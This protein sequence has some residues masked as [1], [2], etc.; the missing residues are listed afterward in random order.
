MSN[1]HAR[2]AIAGVAVAGMI[3]GTMAVGDA[4]GF[5]R[6]FYK[7][8]SKVAPETAKVEAGFYQR[9]YDLSVVI[10]KNEAGNLESY[11]STTGM[12]YPIYQG[13]EDALVGSI[14]DIAGN[15]SE[16]GKEQI[17]SEFSDSEQKEIVGSYMKD[18]VGEGI[19]NGKNFLK[20][21]YD[22]IKSYFE[23]P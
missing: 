23:K 22:K 1:Q 19:E 9:P 6:I 20:S 5:N 8:A 18:K 11:L 3:A 13:S 7:A 12:R 14:E 21:L 15:L 2:N 10:E 4:V 16:S 17:F